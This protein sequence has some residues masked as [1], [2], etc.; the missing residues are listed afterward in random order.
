MSKYIYI[1]SFPENT[2][3]NQNVGVVF[4]ETVKDFECEFTANPL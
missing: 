4:L 2:P 1:N 3:N